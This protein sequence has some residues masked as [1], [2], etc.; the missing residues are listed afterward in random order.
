MPA[1]NTQKVT[2]IET[3]FDQV[4]R[5][6]AKMSGNYYYRGQNNAA[7]ELLPS[8]LRGRME[9]KEDKIYTQIMTECSNDFD[10]IVSHGEI[11]SKMQH[12]GVPTRLL[13]ITSNPLV[14]LY[15]ACEGG[16]KK[17]D[18]KVFVL[19]SNPDI[20]KTFDSD[21]VSILSCLPRF[22]SIDKSRIKSL[23]QKSLYNRINE[24]SD[25]DEIEFNQDK[26]IRRLLHEVKKE[27]PAFE[28]IIN[29]NDLLKDFFYVPKKNNARIIRQSGAFIIFGLRDMQYNNPNYIEREIIVD[30]ASK[31]SIIDQLSCFGISK[32]TLFPEL[33]EV[34]EFIKEKYRG[35]R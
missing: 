25:Q 12:Y 28:N 15:F 2:S 35:W 20:K 11:L 4:P 10:G 21:A 26:T 32:A 18:G 3:Y 19:E 9:E 23:V 1:L 5:L 22:N 16:N 31:K 7:Y 13:D 27:K 6:D 24:E 29:P 14:A 17:I 30:Q 34:A 8:V 33:Y